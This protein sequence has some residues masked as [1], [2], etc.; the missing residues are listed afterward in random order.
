MLSEAESEGKLTFSGLMGG[1]RLG[2]VDGNPCT[3]LRTHTLVDPPFLNLLFLLL[4]GWGVAVSFFP[5]SDERRLALGDMP[6]PSC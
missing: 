3:D 5:T 1:R 6:E 4:P 2:P